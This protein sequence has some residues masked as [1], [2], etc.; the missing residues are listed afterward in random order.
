MRM[1]CAM[2]G[3]PTQP[4]VMIGS[5]AIG[6]KCAKRAGM[7]RKTLAGT[8]AQ[9]VKALTKQQLDP[10]NLPLFADLDDKPTEINCG[11]GYQFNGALGKY[12]C[13]NCHG[14]EATA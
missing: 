1:K 5:E 2:C 7:N 13:P 11:C 14:E 9:F 8:R 4:F 3:K 6:P 10:R 12:G